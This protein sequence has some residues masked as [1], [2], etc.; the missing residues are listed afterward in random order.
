MLTFMEDNM[1]ES[2]VLEICKT[3]S[4]NFIREFNPDKVTPAKLVLDP[5]WIPTSQKATIKTPKE[6]KNKLIHNYWGLQIDEKIT[7]DTLEMHVYSNYEQV[8]QVSFNYG[9]I[10]GD[11]TRAFTYAQAVGIIDSYNPTSWVVDE[12]MYPIVNGK[13]S[14]F[15]VVESTKY[16]YEPKGQWKATYVEE[17]YGT[18]RTDEWYIGYFQSPDVAKE[19]AHLW[20]KRKDGLKVI[21]AGSRGITN[22][23]LLEVIMK[24]YPDADNIWEVVSGTARGV[25]ILG[26]KWSILNNR[27]LKKFPADWEQYGRSAGYKRNVQMSEYAD[28]AIVIILDH[29]KGSEHMAKIMHDCNKPVMVCDVKIVDGKYKCKWRE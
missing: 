27:E 19:Q 7:D 12:W 16:S 5:S 6:W 18:N 11:E 26:E 4:A 9:E 10:W 14:G 24:N 23:Q 28:Q 8:V 15:L 22:Y 29:S 20:Y 3:L 1:K 2:K 21:I 13:H 25:D 17:F